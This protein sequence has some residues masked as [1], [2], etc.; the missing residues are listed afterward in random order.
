MQETMDTPPHNEE[1]RTPSHTR[2]GRV[3]VRTI[4][5]E[6]FLLH[7]SRRYCMN[8]AIAEVIESEILLHIKLFI[9]ICILYDLYH[10]SIP[11]NRQ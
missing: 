1:N 7:F 3:F 10:Q 2:V 5:I 9:F 11:S 6:T 4:P 8:S